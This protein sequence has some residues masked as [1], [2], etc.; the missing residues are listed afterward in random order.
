ML[1]GSAW[2]IAQR[3]SLRLSG[4]LSTVVLARLLTPRDFGIVAIAMLFVGLVEAFGETGERLALLR[5]IDPDRSYYDTA[6]TLQV[7]IGASAALIIF[8]LAPLTSAYFHEP[9]AIPVMQCLAGRALLGGLENIGSV[10]FRKDFQFG[11]LYKLTVRAKLI[12]LAVTMLLAVVLRNYWALAAGI[13]AGQ[14]AFTALSY[15]MHPFRPRLSLARREIF[16]FSVWTLVRTVGIYLTSQVDF[17]AVGGIGTAGAMGRYAVATSVAAS[18]TAEIND[19]MVAVLYPVMSKI[20]LDP[21]AVRALYQR[22]F[23]WSA[24]ICAATGAGVAVIAADYSLLILGPKWTDAAPLIP[25]LALSAAL[26][27]LSSGADTVFDALGLPHRSARLQ[28]IRLAMLA[29]C[30][31]PIAF[32]TRNIEAVAATRLAVSCAFVPI[33]LVSVGR[34]IQLSFKA[35]LGAIWRPVIAAAVM[36]AAVIS[37]S[38]FLPAGHFSRLLVEVPLG[39]ICYAG[40]LIGLWLLSGRPDSPEK[41]ILILARSAGASVHTRWIARSPV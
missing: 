26:L 33:L 14:A 1:R 34:T 22:V 13:L 28:W 29:A 35:Y 12:S 19:P 32:W 2:M 6:W 17:F 18:P 30:I 23:S 39:A 4:V 8:L 11:T 20:R 15:V 5:Q 25:W 21:A 16:A 10:D 37:V 40:T 24:V 31:A 27:G 7:I 9:R 36:A 3:W 38:A 41:D